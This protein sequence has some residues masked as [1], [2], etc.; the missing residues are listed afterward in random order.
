MVMRFLFLFLY[1]VMKVQ[2][3]GDYDWPNV[4]CKLFSQYLFFVTS[5]NLLVLFSFLFIYFRDVPSSAALPVIR[6][7][8]GRQHSMSDRA[9]V[10]M[11]KYLNHFL[12]N[13]D[14]VNCREV[15]LCVCVFF[16]PTILIY[17]WR[18]LLVSIVLGTSSV[19]LFI[20][21]LILTCL[22][23]NLL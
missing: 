3:T 9:K 10:A 7:A 21:C 4:L 15:F 20:F 22:G 2:R 13:M 16:P 5:Y 14:I 18:Y 11:Q 8:L 12:G 23:G 17:Y 1:I 6:P 19:N